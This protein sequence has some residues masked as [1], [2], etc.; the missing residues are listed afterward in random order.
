M[1][2]ATTIFLRYEGTA[3]EAARFYAQTFPAS[4]VGSVLRAP[5]DYPNGKRGD[6]PTVEFTVIAIPCV[7][8]NGGPGPVAAARARRAKGTV[9][10][11]VLARL[12]V[13]RTRAAWLAALARSVDH[14]LVTFDR[15]FKSFDVIKLSLLSIEGESAL[16]EAMT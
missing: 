14:E 16:P 5:G 11:L 7:G 9:G 12:D 4:A 15:R 13:G 1:A 2:A 8:L 3:L 10:F 6:V